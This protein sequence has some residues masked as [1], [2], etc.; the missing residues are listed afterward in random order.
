MQKNEKHSQ[1]VKPLTNPSNF[2]ALVKSFK[3]L[4]ISEENFQAK[5][6]LGCFD[7]LPG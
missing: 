4:A 5:Q 1:P 2:S 7:S 6:K 3:F